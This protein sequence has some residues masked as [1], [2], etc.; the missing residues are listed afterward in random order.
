M[1]PALALCAFSSVA[2]GQGLSGLFGFLPNSGQFPAAIRFVRYSTNFSYLTRDSF[3]LFNGVRI[4]IAGI[5]PNAQPVGGSPTTTLYNFYQGKDASQWV[6]NA[7]LFNTATLNNVYPGISAVFST[8]TQSI[9]GPTSVG[10]GEVDFSIA[11]GAD[12]SPIQLNVLNTGATP[13][14]GP[15]GGIWFTGGGIPGVFIVSAQATQTTGTTSS[16][17]TCSLIINASGSL[18]VQVPNRNPALETDVA[19]TFPDYDLN[20]SQPTGLVASSIQIPTSFGQDGT[21]PNSNCGGGCSKALVADVNSDGTPVWVTL[22]GGSGNDDAEFATP[23]QAGV[24][25]AGTTES[26][27]FPVTASAPNPSPGGPDDLFLAYFDAA[28]G[29]LLNATYA[30][31][32]GMP[33]VRQQISSSNGDIAIDGGSGAQG[34]ILRWQPAQNRFTFRFLGDNPVFAVGFDP[35][36]N[37]F[38]ATAQI[39]TAGSALN[40]GE[41]DG[42][43]KPIG[44]TVG[45]ELPATL[46]TIQ[47]QP[48]G[49]NAVWVVY[50]VG[51]AGISAGPATWVARVAPALG[52]LVGNVRALDQGSVTSMGLT[53][54]A[55]LKLLVQ[56]P[57]PTE[58]TSPNA[59]LVAACPGTSYF[60]VFSPSAQLVYATYVPSQ[61]FNVA[62]QNES[63]A[64]PSAAIACFAS[65]AG[66]VPA[67]GAAP[68]ELITLTGGGFGPP[69]PVFTAPGADGTYPL[70]AAGFSVKIGGMDAPVIAVAL[71]LI[72]VQ[73]PFELANQLDRTLPIEVFQG[74]LAFPSIPMGMVEFSLNLFD[75]GDRNNTMNLP[76]LAALNQDGTVNSVDNPAAVGSVVSLFGS[77]LGSLSPPLQT[78]GISPV[79]PAGPLSTSR[80]VTGCWGCGAVLYYGSA[81]GLSTAVNQINVRLSTDAPGTGV[82]PQAIGISIADS[83]E[84]IFAE[85]TGV[86]F[87]R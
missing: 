2:L 54:A 59:P 48:A 14:V 12:P 62:A 44:S 13:F 20:T 70:T 73:V 36:S 28:S 46:D 56:G 47:L 51:Q 79:P 80:L 83:I 1:R 68:G 19:I 81:P 10:L 64:V 40:I 23:S 22:F 42:S 32:Q 65:T 29:K 71:G 60:A 18:S 72:A 43:G 11:P 53:P 50:Q 34:Y 66:R 74:D 78:G 17:V 3:V 57:A 30:G 63:S 21:Q 35:A 37:L 55:N 86:V 25:V 69:T 87:I 61:G 49:G 84:G 26:A 45:I 75:T 8:T 4:Q 24:S 15:G 16:P 27:D 76:A 31:L 33:G 38:Y 9:Q 82:R 5:D 77:G 52:Q 39:S 67:T 58:P 85:P 6:T 7:H 41:L